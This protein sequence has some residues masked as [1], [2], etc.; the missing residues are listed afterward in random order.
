VRW[1]PVGALFGEIEP[2][3][4]DEVGLDEEVRTEVPWESEGFESVVD[5]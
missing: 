3:F 2:L 1:T 4:E 5:T